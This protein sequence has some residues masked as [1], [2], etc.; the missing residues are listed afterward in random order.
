MFIVS[1]VEYISDVF[2]HRHNGVLNCSLTYTKG[3]M[4][5]KDFMNLFNFAS[6]KTLYVGVERECFLVDSRGAISPLAPAVIRRL[7]NLERFGYELSAC[8]LEERVGPCRIENVKGC[9]LANNAELQRVEDELGF[10]RLYTEV[11]PADMPLDVYPDPTGRYQDITRDMPEE[12]LLVACR[13]AAVHIHIG[14]PNHQ[15]ALDVY[16]KVITKW[17]ELCCMGDNSNG[18]RI[19]IYKIMAN[20]IKPPHYDSWED[21]RNEAVKNGFVSDPRSCWH[22]IRISVHGTIEF[23]MFGSVEDIDKVAEWATVCHRICK[24]ALTKGV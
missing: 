11:A 22:I 23:R 18:R 16:N 19:G 14:M 10:K 21:Y 8:Q 13:V 9:L 12:I 4:T 24:D 2:N 7:G 20:D 5:M 17:G 15:I 6:D 3:E 1:M